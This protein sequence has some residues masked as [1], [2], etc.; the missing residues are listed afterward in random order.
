MLTWVTQ[1]M[2]FAGLSIK[3]YMFFFLISGPLIFL[4]NFFYFTLLQY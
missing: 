1:F 2:G 3:P 4:I